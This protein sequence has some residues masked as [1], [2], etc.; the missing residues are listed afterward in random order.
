LH[1]TV[2]YLGRALGHILTSLYSKQQH[3]VYQWPL[4]N[5]YRIPATYA[6]LLL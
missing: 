4:T 6:M 1:V 5:H 3:L 2:E